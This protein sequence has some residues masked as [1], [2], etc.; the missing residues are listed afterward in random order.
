[1]AKLR[2]PIV[3]SVRSD[4]RVSRRVDFLVGED[5]TRAVRIVLGDEPKP[6]RPRGPAKDG[7]KHCALKPFAMR[8]TE[9]VSHPG[10]RRRTGGAGRSR[11][12]AGG[13]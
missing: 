3:I 2:L 5:G 6:Q 4:D 10:K 8:C 1:M 12:S 11:R 13:A 7:K 9:S